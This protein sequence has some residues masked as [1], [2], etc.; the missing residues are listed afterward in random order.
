[1]KNEIFNY[2]GN[3]ITFQLGNGD[4]M[5]N[6][7]EMAKL[8]GK[9]PNHFLRTQTTKEFIDE[10][11]ALR[12]CNPTDLVKVINGGNNFGTWM[13]EDVALEFARW[14]NPSFAIW[15]NDRIKELMKFGMTATPERLE[16]IVNNPDLVIGLATELKKERK[17]KEKLQNQIIELEPARI[18]TESIKISETDILIRDLAKMLN[19]AGIDIGQ[20]R[21]YGWLVDNKYLIRQRKWSESKQKYRNIYTPTQRASDMGL[22][23]LVPRPIQTRA[24]EPPIT[25]FTCYV[26]GKGQVYFINK[27]FELKQAV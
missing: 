2:K 15:C 18:Y 7:T 22:I 13:H 5:V 16:D 19:Q 3:S 17:E 12:K 25:Q 20:N 27:F 14:L 24:G 21:L 26:T 9:S 8:F 11:S 23:K 10:L 4:V 6:A 1:M